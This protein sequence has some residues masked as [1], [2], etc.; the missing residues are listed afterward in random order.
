MSQVRVLSVAGLCFGPN[1][2]GN[3][4][5]R[6]Y[7]SISFRLLTSS[8]NKN[9]GIKISENAYLYRMRYKNEEA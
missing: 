6:A 5:L 4:E 1:C 2:N 7:T 8:E 9:E 3:R